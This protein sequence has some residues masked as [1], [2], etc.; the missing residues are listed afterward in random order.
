MRTGCRGR[1]RLRA[2]AVGLGLV[3]G[4]ENDRAEAAERFEPHAG[5]RWLSAER[6]GPDG[7][8]PGE[9]RGSRGDDVDNNGMAAP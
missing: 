8:V 9:V 2:G 1:V 7:D 4:G 3:G 6:G 5:Q